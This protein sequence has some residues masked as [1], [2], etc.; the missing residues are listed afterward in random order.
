MVG[1]FV[2]GHLSEKAKRVV[3]LFNKEISFLWIYF[4]DRDKQISFA[5]EV[6]II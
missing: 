4:T 2:K 1:W 6:L 3:N 5:V